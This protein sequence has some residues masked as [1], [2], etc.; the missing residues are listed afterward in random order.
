MHHC[1][2]QLNGRGSDL[3]TTIAPRSNMWRVKLRQSDN[4]VAFG[5]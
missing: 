1:G 4:A 5:S 2:P 3:A